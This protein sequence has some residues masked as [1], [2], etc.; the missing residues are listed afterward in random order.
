M[1]TDWFASDTWTVWRWKWFDYLAAQWRISSV[2][3]IHWICCRLSRLFCNGLLL[4]CF[5]S[6]HD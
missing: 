2:W 3:E 5:C 1:L 6:A 4:L